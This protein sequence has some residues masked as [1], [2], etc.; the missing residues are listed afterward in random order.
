MNPDTNGDYGRRIQRFCVVFSVPGVILG[1]CV[2]VFGLMN[3]S[4]IETAKGWLGVFIA[5]FTLGGAGATLGLCI[6]C[7]IA[8]TEFLEGPAGAKW[9]STIGTRNVTVARIACIVLG[10]LITGLLGMMTWMM[11]SLQPS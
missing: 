1:L 5:P 8:P 6:A 3:L 9:M 7:A 4:E 11:A 10:L 2:S